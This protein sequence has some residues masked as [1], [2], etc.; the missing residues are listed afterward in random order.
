MR[1]SRHRACAIVSGV[2]GNGMAT[3]RLDTRIEIA[4]VAEGVFCAQARAQSQI[5]SNAAI[6]VNLADVLVVDAHSKASAAASLIAQIKKEITP[7][8][9]RYV[10]NSHFHWD[11]IQGNQAYR[12]E[13]GGKI[14]FIASE[15]TKQWMSD[16]A[17][18]RMKASLDDAVK[19]I[20]AQ[21]SRRSPL[22]YQAQSDKFRAHT[23]GKVGGDHR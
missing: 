1:G 18:K 9:V 23:A 10:A 4:E 22:M 16:L 12:R 6:F 20:D 13:G 19:Q 8:P 15:P 7:K 21:V 17:V 14:D 5:N 11:H 2:S 3:L